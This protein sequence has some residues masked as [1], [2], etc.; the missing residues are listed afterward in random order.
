[1]Q[2]RE[3]ISLIY[4]RQ[5]G[6]G[7]YTFSQATYCVHSCDCAKSFPSLYASSAER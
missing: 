7:I 5:S 6:V 3:N 2:K 1:M 4:L